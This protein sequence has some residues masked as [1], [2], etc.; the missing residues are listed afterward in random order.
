MFCRARALQP[1]GKTRAR[2]EPSQ[3]DMVG[4]L[5]A[6]TGRVTA[7]GDDDQRIMSFSAALPDIFPAF[8]RMHGAALR[9][10][11]LSLNYRRGRGS[12]QRGTASLSAAAC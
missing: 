8:R 11:H 9:E 5:A 10:A 12:C 7:V 2:P 1:A 4:L 6:G 3:L